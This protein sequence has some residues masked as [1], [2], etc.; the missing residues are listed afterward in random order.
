LEFPLGIEM[1]GLAL[2]L[3]REVQQLSLRVWEAAPGGNASEPMSELA[4]VPAAVPRPV[5]RG[6]LQ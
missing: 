4:V 3:R 1:I 5:D 2:I 6:L